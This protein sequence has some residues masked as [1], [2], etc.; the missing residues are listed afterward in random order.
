M[1]NVKAIHG[2]SREKL[3]E[4][5]DNSIDSCVTDPPYS[6]VSIQKRFGKP[7][8]APPKSGGATGVYTRAAAGF[9]GQSWDTGEVVHDPVFWA[10]IHRVLKPGAHLLAFAGTRTYH[11]MTCAIEDGGFEVRDMISWVYGVGFPKSHDIS[12][13]IDKTRTDETA[14]WSGWGTSLK[15]ALEPIVLA[16][17]PLSEPT[18]AANVLKWGAGALNIDASRIETGENLN[19]GAYAKVGNRTGRWPANVCHDNSDEVLALFPD[20]GKSTGGRITNISKTSEI[21]GGG[22]GLGQR[23]LTADDVRGDPGFGDTGSA[24][25]FFYSA[26]ASKADRIGTN[27]PTVKPV[28]LMRWLCR[29]ITSPNGTILDPFAGSGT[30][31]IAAMAD[32]FDAILIEREAQFYADIQHRLKHFSKNDCDPFIDGGNNKE[33]AQLPLFAPQ[34]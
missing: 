28:S 31:G 26:K 20:T 29:L 25:R 1:A 30:T 24:A 19:G 34:S 13:A 18:I 23:D 5:P 15:P 27:H 32:G 3:K 2:D 9:M 12:V 7:S 8:S 11:R 21:Y 10:E 4:I 14:A 22:K 6:L 16:R 17:K 33:E